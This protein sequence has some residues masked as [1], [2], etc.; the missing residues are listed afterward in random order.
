[1]GMQEADD[2]FAVI[3]IAEA[4]RHIEALT[5]AVDT[6]ITL[7]LIADRADVQGDARH[8]SG[9]LSD[10]ARFLSGKNLNGFGVFMTINEMDGKGR[11]QKNVVRVSALAVDV[12]VNKATT[13]QVR[14]LEEA[15]KHCDV[16]GVPPTIVVRSNGQEN[17]HLI[18]RVE[19]CSRDDFRRYQK[20][21]ADHFDGDPSICDLPRLLRLAGFLHQ[22]V[23]PRRTKL[24]RAEPGRVYATHDLIQALGLVAP[25]LGRGD[26]DEWA[27]AKVPS[28]LG[29]GVDPDQNSWLLA[30]SALT[31]KSTY[32]SLDQCGADPGRQTDTG[33][34]EDTQ[35]YRHVVWP[36]SGLLQ[37]L[38]PRH[39]L[40]QIA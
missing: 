21:L 23:E 37:S 39:Q 32:E 33:I 13:G 12:D 18:W 5:G 29:L 35:I 19:D 17:Y 31:E 14:S 27:R 25:E 2:S 40:R 4:E 20:L 11:K 16:R 38:L 36:H 34:E 26:I 15:L 10:N 8:F 30:A 6:K 7:Q 22:K 24:V 9:R 3:D 1:L 28:R